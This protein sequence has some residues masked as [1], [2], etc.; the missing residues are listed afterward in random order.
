MLTD[1]GARE[2]FFVFSW[3]LFGLFLSFVFVVFSGWL[4]CIRCVFVLFD[5]V[6]LGFAWFGLV[7]FGLVWR[8]L[9]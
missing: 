1:E 5:L 9:I 6:W 8:V 7:E 4:C 3:F 2:F